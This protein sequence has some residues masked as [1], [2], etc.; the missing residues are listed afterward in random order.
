MPRCAGVQNVSLPMDMCQE[1]SQYKPTTVDV[2]ASAE[3]HTYQGT[4]AA[5]AAATARVGAEVIEI[6][7]AIFKLP[8]KAVRGIACGAAAGKSAT[9]RPSQIFRWRQIYPAQR[10]LATLALATCVE[11]DL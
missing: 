4:A 1:M 10:S 2:T 5:S 8:R 6:P 7:C 11:G 9:L 3:L